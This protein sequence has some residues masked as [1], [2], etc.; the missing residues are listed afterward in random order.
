MCI[1]ELDYSIILKKQ[2]SKV[3]PIAFQLLQKVEGCRDALCFYLFQAFQLQNAL[4]FLYNYRYAV[5]ERQFLMVFASATLQTISEIFLQA[6]QSCPVKFRC[7][8]RKECSLYKLLM[9]YL[10]LR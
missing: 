10:L 5:M 9:I 8:A 2:L 6:C 4:F 3:M 1:W 7:N